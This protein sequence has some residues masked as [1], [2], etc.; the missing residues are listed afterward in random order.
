M[1]QLRQLQKCLHPRGIREKNLQKTIQKFSEYTTLSCTKGKKEGKKKNFFTSVTQKAHG[2]YICVLD[3][4]DVVLCGQIWLEETGEFRV[5]HPSW[6]CSHYR[7]TCLNS[8]L[9]LPCRGDQL[10]HWSLCYPCPVEIAF[11]KKKISVWDKGRKANGSN[12]HLFLK[13]TKSSQSK[14]QSQTNL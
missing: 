8:D 6:M 14:S 11:V 7:F 5:T 4:A 13:V 9:D 1:E 3:C 10:M 12:L 2:T